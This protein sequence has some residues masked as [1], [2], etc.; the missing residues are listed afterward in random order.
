MSKNPVFLFYVETVLWVRFL[1]PPS[2]HCAYSR[3][4]SWMHSE[5]SRKPSKQC[6]SL[7]VGPPTAE[8]SCTRLWNSD[9]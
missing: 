7:Q 5:D 2:S 9:A 3:Y 8:P 4:Y 6:Y 1:W